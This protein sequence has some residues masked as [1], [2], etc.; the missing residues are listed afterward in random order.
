MDPSFDLSVLDSN[1]G[2]VYVQFTPDC[3]N[4]VFLVL[5]APFDRSH[6]VGSRE[7]TREGLGYTESIEWFLEA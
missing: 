6:L 5:M 2:Y 3:R 4:E 1:P 7:V